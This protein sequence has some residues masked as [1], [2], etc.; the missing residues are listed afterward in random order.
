MK[1]TGRIKTIIFKGE[2]VSV[3][4][5]DARVFTEDQKWIPYTDISLVK[6]GK[7]K[8]GETWLSSF[9]ESIYQGCRE[10]NKGVEV[11]VG[12]IVTERGFKN[13]ESIG[14][15]LP[16]VDVLEEVPPDL[17]DDMTVKETTTPEDVEG[18]STTGDIMAE[19]EATHKD[20]LI[21]RQTCIKAAGAVAS[22]Q[23]L[24]I[25]EIVVVA[26]RLETYVLTGK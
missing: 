7:Y 4:L 20:V 13:I 25:K 22:G 11:E 19:I 6:D 15:K 5:E 14:L 1:L 9:K 12:V 3:L 24:D 21:I 16:E 17:P 18:A 23:G 26:K 10:L 2:R 8:K